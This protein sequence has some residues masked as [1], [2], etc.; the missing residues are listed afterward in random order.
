MGGSFLLLLMLII[1][2]APFGRLREMWT[3]LLTMQGIKW[4]VGALKVEFGLEAFPVRLFPYATH[5]DFA[6]D[7]AIC[8]CI[9]VL[10][11]LLV[12]GRT[13]RVRLLHAACFAAAYALWS[14]TMTRWTTLQVHLRW[15]SWFDFALVLVLLPLAVRIAEWIVPETRQAGSAETRP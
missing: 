4:L 8:P 10:Y 2:Q 11:A 15:S 1:R 14:W 3:V 5:Q 9:A 13:M 6:T 7:F 12:R